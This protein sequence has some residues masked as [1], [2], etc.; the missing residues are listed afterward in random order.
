[1]AIGTCRSPFMTNQGT[2]MMMSTQQQQQMMLTQRSSARSAMN[3]FLYT[4]SGPPTGRSARE[5]LIPKD[6]P[7]LLYKDKEWVQLWDYDQNAYYWWNDKDQVAQWEQP[8]METYDPSAGYYTNGGTFNNLQTATTPVKEETEE[9]DTYTES[10]YESSGG[11]LTDFSSDHHHH[12]DY[13][14]GY[15]GEDGSS[16][17]TEWQ[18]YWDEQ[19]QAK[20]W[21]NNY[22]G[23]ASWT[24]P[25]TLLTITNTATNHT[26]GSATGTTAATL[27]I[28]NG[29]A[30][31]NSSSG[32]QSGKHGRGWVSYLD[33]ATGQLYWHNV[34][35]GEVKWDV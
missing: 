24:M 33:E 9:D 20:Y 29:P 15:D 22:T 23:E 35:T 5:G 11:A 14:Y 13:G 25:E 6:A 12:V 30:V 21:Y 2:R 7:K 1:M 19:A 31:S 10:G 18:E 27:A 32:G 26:Q 28:E 4:T 17:A 8:G 3:T 16:L 34:N